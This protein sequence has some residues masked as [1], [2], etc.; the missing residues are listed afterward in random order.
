MAA[1]N[2]T[3]GDA[4]KRRIE[5]AG[6]AAALIDIGFCSHYSKQAVNICPKLPFGGGSARK[7]GEADVWVFG[8]KPVRVGQ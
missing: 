5:R 2:S 7:C 4:L 6:Q 1:L 3:L 8:K